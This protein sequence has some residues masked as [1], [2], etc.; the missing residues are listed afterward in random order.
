MAAPKKKA[1]DET[2]NITTDTSNNNLEQENKQLRSELDEMK[3]MMK[4]LLESQNASKEQSKESQKID[5]DPDNIDES[6]VD[7]P[8]NKQINVTS[9]FYGGMTL[10]GTNSKKIRFD[11]FGI[12]RPISYGDLIDVC[13]RHRDLAEQG[14]FFIHSKDAVKALYLEQ[15]YVNILDAKKIGNLLTLSESEIDSIMKSMTDIQKNTVENVVIQGIIDGDHKYTNW[16]KVN[17][18]NKHCKRNLQKIANERMQQN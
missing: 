9:L 12:T 18:V 6:Y 11:K 1:N 14:A 2:N 5:S 15:S 10:Y 8:Q 16:N 17:I 13:N 4:Q 7:I 3:A